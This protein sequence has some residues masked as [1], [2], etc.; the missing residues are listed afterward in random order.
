MVNTIQ[1]DT[2]RLLRWPE[3]HS[4]TGICRSHAHALA[5]RGEFPVPIKLGSRA[6]AWLAS[7]IDAWIQSRIAISRPSEGE[8]S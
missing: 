5:A 3:V 1:R 7:E 2:D 4:R 8:L 6:S